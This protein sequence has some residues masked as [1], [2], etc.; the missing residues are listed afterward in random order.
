[1]DRKLSHE[2]SWSVDFMNQIQ[3]ARV[4]FGDIQML[5]DED[6]F[7]R[8]ELACRKSY[9]TEM[10][11]TQ[12]EWN[13][14]HGHGPLFIPYK[15]FGDAYRKFVEREDAEAEKKRL[16]AIRKRRS[17]RTIHTV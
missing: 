9:T 6:L 1:M 10:R 14:R 5:L 15:S 2:R 3:E 7:K 4:W 17:Q 13:R 12:K 8:Y 11:R 16:E